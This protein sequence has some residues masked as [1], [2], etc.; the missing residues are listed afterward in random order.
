MTV[1]PP[2]YDALVAQSTDEVERSTGFRVALVL[3]PVGLAV[4]GA[5]PRRP[6]HT[7]RPRAARRARG[8]G[9]RRARRLDRR[10][11]P[12]PRDRDHPLLL[13]LG[14]PARARLRPASAGLPRHAAPPRRRRP[15]RA[16]EL[17]RDARRP[18]RVALPAHP[19]GQ[20]D[21]HRLEGAHDDD[22]RRHRLRRP[23]ARLRAPGLPPAR[24]LAALVRVVPR[25][26]RDR[27]EADLQPGRR[28]RVGGAREGLQARGRR[29][30]RRGAAP[31]A[32]HAGGDRAGPRLARGSPGFQHG[33]ALQLEGSTLVF[34]REGS[35]TPKSIGRAEALVTAATPFVAWLRAFHR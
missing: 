24:A 35:L 32:L 31:R 26:R 11:P 4:A 9:P 14:R 5:L 1:Q 20:E 34:Y 16:R 3:A 22:E 23:A 28:A 17:R 8:R 7:R 19:A 10:P 29:R 6:D 25:L 12:R 33:V 18:R 27:V 30:R 2:D 21:E 13:R 15:V